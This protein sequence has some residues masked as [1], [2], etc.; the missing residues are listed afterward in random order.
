MYQAANIEVEPSGVPESE[1]LRR[2]KYSG[3]LSM[4][5]FPLVSIYVLTCVFIYMYVCIY[6]RV[7]L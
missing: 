5:P 6:T 7:P 2:R 3:M 1:Y 4:Y